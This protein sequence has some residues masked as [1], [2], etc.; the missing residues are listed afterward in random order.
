MPLGEDE[1]AT[2]QDDAAAPGRE[3]LF[4]FK[5]LVFATH[6]R[7]CNCLPPMVI[8]L[9]VFKLLA[10]ATHVR[11]CLSACRSWLPPLP[12]CRGPRGM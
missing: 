10:V 4:V 9:C 3:S 1:K 8:N 5:L 7:F 12:L 2:M 6:V 11:F